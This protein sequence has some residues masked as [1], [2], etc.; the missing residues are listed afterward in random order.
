MV[1]YHKPHIGAKAKDPNCNSALGWT[2]QIMY[3][4]CK[5]FTWDNQNKIAGTCDAPWRNAKRG[6][7]PQENLAHIPVRNDS[8][9]GAKDQTHSSE[10][11]F[12]SDSDIA[13]FVLLYFLFY[14][15]ISV[16]KKL[17]ERSIVFY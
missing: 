3:R 9:R 17:F 11:T 2:A 4:K 15:I 5:F 8:S 16:V 14:Q 6:V 12:A 13:S 7:A 10:A 1:K